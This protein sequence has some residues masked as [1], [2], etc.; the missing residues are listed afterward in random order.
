MKTESAM[1]VI[2]S[3]KECCFKNRVDRMMLAIRSAD[4]TRIPF[5]FLSSSQ[6]Q[7]AMFTPM[8]LYTWMLGNRFVGVSIS[9]K[10]CTSCVNT[11]SRANSWGLR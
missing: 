8:E 6:C 5:F 7:T 11:L 1:A 4:K 10:Y 2:T 9:Y 3:N